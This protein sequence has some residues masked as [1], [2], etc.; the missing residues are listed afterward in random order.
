MS[1]KLSI[2]I[3][4]ST[5]WDREWYQCFQGFRW[6]LVDLVDDLL[7]QLNAH[8][9]FPVF[10]F[11]GQTI[12]L[13]DYLEIAPEKREELADLIKQGRILIGPW[14]VMPDEYLVSGESLIKNMLIGNRICR[15]FGVEPMK[16]GYI[17]DIF[18]HTAQMPQ[19]FGG[20]GIKGALLGRGTNEA[21]Y[22]AFLNWR[23]PDGS[24]CI[25]FKL[26]DMNGYG[27]FWKRIIKQTTPSTTEAQFNEY[28][29]AMVEHER[30]RS[31][32]PVV[33]LMDGN[34]HNPIHIEDL[35]HKARLEKLYP[36]AT[37]KIAPLPEMVKE[38]EQ[39]NEKLQLVE[40][41]INDTART[42]EPYNHLITNTLSSRYDIKKENDICQELMEKWV[43]P[44]IALSRQTK[45]PIR[46]SY[47]EKAYNYLIQNHPHDSICGCSQDQVHRDMHYR[48][49]QVK[50][51]GNEVIQYGLNALTNNTEGDKTLLTIANTLPFPRKETVTVNLYF[52]ENYPVWSEPFGY[53]D[54]NS[55]LILDENGNEIEYKINS[56]VRN[57]K[58][59]FSGK[60]FKGDRHTVTFEADLKAGGLTQ[61][62]IVPSQGAVR[63]MTGLQ[64]SETSA[65]N[66]FIKLSVTPDGTLELFDKRTKETYKNLLSFIDD[67]EIGDGWFHAAPSND[68][69][70]LSAG[71]PVYISVTENGP[72]KCTFKIEKHM[73]IPQ[74]I[75]RISEMLPG[76]QRSEKK[77]ELVLTAF[78]SITK[79]SSAVNIKLT[80]DNK[81]K[82]HRL[83]LLMPTGITADRYYAS[84]AFCTVERKV[85]I[86]RAREKWREA[87]QHEK[88]MTSFAYKR[89]G[90]GS[91]IAF[92]SGGGLHEIGSF[93]DNEGS[94][95][96]TLL[97]CIGRAEPAQVTEDGQLI[98][99]WD[100]RFAFMP[101]TAKDS[102]GD[103][104]RYRDTLTAG[105]QYCENKSTDKPVSH[106][107][108]SLDGDACFSTLKVAED[109]E[110]SIF[111]LY[112]AGGKSEKCILRF[113]R[114][115]KKACLV[116]LEEEEPELLKAEQSISLF[117]APHKIVTVK[118]E[119]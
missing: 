41:E 2:Y 24:E 10:T 16:Y 66:D 95:A 47:G 22:Q 110:A 107:F 6:R 97:R 33:L 62:E 40:G 96:V 65:E 101:L 59:I 104:T 18:G 103:I 50:E 72:A 57:K 58:H 83:R 56:I 90:N 85:G 34:D 118:I 92:V 68:I 23:S 63:C 79:S 84:E 54:I 115:I 1:G 98:G 9:E 82:D 32:I 14:Y 49:D 30:S 108:Y 20:F 27:E 69:S 86:D 73:L 8:P 60:V 80:V 39:Y 44:F 100:Y 12:V 11:D 93:N 5:H 55:F 19:I 38:L 116:N 61:Y 26:S 13:E 3:L 102:D 78:V 36:E 106:S 105:I 111:R 15:E 75:D 31:E 51:I 37:V 29:K 43:C 42:R 46:K 17:C 74:S 67:G 76:I 25:T 77:I 81:A 112:N 52:D 94:L 35:E 7:K 28:L 70:V 71:A 113:D 117:I 64:S 119:Y 87:P 53:E 89:R 45:T 114:E 4:S 21:D 48:F 99:K 88:A 91:G 109:G